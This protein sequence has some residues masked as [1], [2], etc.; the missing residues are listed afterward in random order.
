[1]NTVLRDAFIRIHSEDVVGRLRAEFTA[2]YQGAMYVAKLRTDAPVYEKIMAWRNTKEKKFI[3]TV[4]VPKAKKAPFLDELMMERER[5]RLLQSSDPEDVKKGKEMV[6][7]TSIFQLHA[8]QE[9]LVADTDLNHTGLGDMS[10]RESRLQASQDNVADEV[11]AIGQEE[12]FESSSETLEDRDDS[13]Q[14]C[15]TEKI[16]DEEEEPTVFEK[17]LG[18]KRVSAPRAT[19]I[20]LPVTF[21]P[22]PKKVCFK[23]LPKPLQQ[24]L[25]LY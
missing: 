17:I 22:V 4:K 8:A 11:S 7:P 12:N 20:W 3:R 25:T 9:D 1:M 5:L 10:T 16:Q 13:T 2:R 18:K 15:E 21:P 14:D 19:E 23:A 24:E 6:T